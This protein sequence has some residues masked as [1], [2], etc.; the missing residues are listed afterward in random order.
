[1]WDHP[2]VSH[3]LPTELKITYQAPLILINWKSTI[4]GAPACPFEVSRKWDGNRADLA[5]QLT[6]QLQRLESEGR[7]FNMRRREFEKKLSL[8]SL[9]ESHRM[10]R[11]SRTYLFGWNSFDSIRFTPP[12]PVP[13]LVKENDKKGF[14]HENYCTNLGMRKDWLVE[15]PHYVGKFKLRDFLVGIIILL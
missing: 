14:K 3:L 11:Y 5:N 10:A 12:V 13:V 2:H 7:N 15:N 6:G 4:S 8:L 1:M 9:L